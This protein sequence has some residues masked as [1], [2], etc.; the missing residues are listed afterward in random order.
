VEQLVF[1]W[2][3]LG[4]EL[5]TPIP[6]SLE[7]DSLRLAILPLVQVA[8]LPRLMMRPP[9]VRS[10][11]RPRPMLVHHIVIS[12]FK[13]EDENRSGAL[14]AE[15]LCEKWT[16]TRLSLFRRD[17]SLLRRKNSLFGSVGNSLASH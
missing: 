9:E 1:R 3:R 10:L 13:T 15:Q 11:T 12:I 17:N 14:A 5:R 16:L 2:L 4:F 7:R 8:T 6:E